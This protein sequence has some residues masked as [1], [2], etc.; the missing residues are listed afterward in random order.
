MLVSLEW[1]KEY[2][3]LPAGLTPEQI[4]HD[5]T[6][7]TV[8]VEGVVFTGQ[9]LD[10]VCVAEVLQADKVPD[11][12]L[13]LTTCDAGEHG[14][15]SVVCGATNVRAGLRVA[16]ALPG[17][18][19][20]PKGAAEAVEVREAEVRGL[21]SHAVICSAG[22]IGL[23]AVFPP[24]DEQSIMELDELAGIPAGT[25]LASA[26]GFTDAVFEIDNKSLTNRPDL[27]GHYGIARELAAI[28]DAPL[29]TLP[30]AP[31]VAASDAL[32]APSDAALCNRFTATVFEGVTVTGAPLAMR[33]R[34]ARVGQRSIDLFVDLTN[35]VM[36]ACGQPSH[37]YDADELDLPMCARASRDGEAVTLLDGSEVHAHPSVPYIADARRPLAVAG[38]MG[39]EASGVTPGSRRIFLEMANFDARLIRAASQRTG[40]RTE[41]SSRFEKALDTQRIDA[42]LGLFH[43]LLADIQP[44]AKAVA[45]QD[46]AAAPTVPAEVRVGHRYITS[47]LGVD[48][49]VARITRYLESLGFSVQESAG[50]FTLTAPTWR[51]TGDVS[52]P[53]DIVEEVA[54]LHG[55]DNFR[56][57]PPQVALTHLPRAKRVP[58]DRQVRELL[59]GAGLQEVFTYPWAKRAQ[60]QAAADSWQEFMTLEMPPAPD[61]ER[62][63]PVLLPNLLEAVDTNLRYFDTFGLFEVGAVYP[64]AGEGVAAAAVLV[65]DDAGH[66]FRRVRGVVEHVIRGAQLKGVELR[67]SIEPHDW[68]DPSV[69]LDI[70]SGGEVIGVVGRVS[71]RSK[72]LAGIDRAEVL[73]FECRLEALQFQPTRENSYQRVAEFPTSWFDVSVLLADTVPWA[74]VEA[75]VVG[76]DSLLREVRWVGEY[77]GDGVPQ[78]ARSLTLRVIAG[79]EDRTLVSE[80]VDGLRA[81][82]LETLEKTLGARQR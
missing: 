35:Y 8:E 76:M 74:Q 31:E 20:Y 38:V 28:Y 24:A 25:P 37:A 7:A 49:P 29:S 5:L 9:A 70:H 59:A 47:R 80:E 67:P 1:L 18:Q 23:A 64:G 58:L 39:G 50:I 71:N 51:S 30:R 42:G 43:Q 68:V 60:L 61:Q 22:E 19:I 33:S 16:L 17:A 55:Y 75:A 27:W 32:L 10:R 56:F 2:V 63:R 13:T 82:V 14:V 53:A 12:K 73:A 45:F 52:L 3:D 40:A 36:F 46:A 65:G 54:R 72:R 81:R 34:L 41:A 44:E 66:L 77:R 15:L 11:T 62:L 69:R 79:A 57:V 6:L 21:A 4:M 26:I 48:F 78:G